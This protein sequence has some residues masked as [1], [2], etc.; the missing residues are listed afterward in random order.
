[1]WLINGTSGDFKGWLYRKIIL[2]TIIEFG[3]AQIKFKT[4]RHEI[5]YYILYCPPLNHFIGLHM[6]DG[7]GY[8]NELE[9]DVAWSRMW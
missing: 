6:C 7:Q 2:D 3:W 9:V 8:D 1:M 5:E 4:P